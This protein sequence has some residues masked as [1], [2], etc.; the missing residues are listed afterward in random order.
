MPDRTDGKSLRSGFLH[1]AKADPDRPA[2]IV[3]GSTRSYGEIQERAS[4]WA[5]SIMDACGQRPERVGLY[6]HRSEV[7]YT[8]TMAALL[9][10][11]TFVPLNPTFP[12]QKTAAMIAQADLDAIIVDSTCLPK[13]DA[14]IQSFEGSCILTPDSNGY[15]GHVPVFSSAEL[16]KSQP[17]RFFPPLTPE[18]TAYLLFTSGSTGAPKGFQ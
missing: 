2:V 5:G 10:G 15:N 14:V 11:A 1:H 6:T 7:A 3:R 18:D 9:S 13:L 16:E 12:V 8:G 17:L 4:R